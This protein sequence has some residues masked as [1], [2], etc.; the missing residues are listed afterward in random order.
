M[1]ARFSALSFFACALALT[2]AAWPN[3]THAQES[4]TQTYQPTVG[5]AGKDV[6]WVPTPQTLVDEMLNIAK[7]KAGEYL[8]DLGSGDGRTV[9]TA[10][11]RGLTALGI[12]YNPDM[13]ELARRNARQAGVEKS[14]SFH[15]GD[16]FEADLSKADIITM[17]LLPTINE[18]LKPS[19]LKLKPGT[20]V[21]SNSFTMGDWEADQSVFV[22]DDCQSYCTAL[23]WIVPAR[24]EGDWQL[25]DQ[26]LRLTQQYQRL[27][28]TLGGTA[29][30]EAQ[31]QGD[32]IRFSVGNV[33]Y[34]G[35]VKNGTMSGRTEG[36]ASTSWSARKL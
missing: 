36:S 3:S 7:V 6:V 10:A 11:Q 4:S 17:F 5:Q 1:T 34:V 30:S 25:G 28:G 29:L 27:T 32:A 24:V 13:A 9:I 18:R 19:L 12:E 15:T 2:V 16:L 31:M 23:L 20:R 35:T 33:R 22:S 26:T 8:I 14:A 21:V